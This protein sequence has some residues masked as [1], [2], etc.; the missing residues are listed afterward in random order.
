MTEKEIDKL[1]E[2][3]RKRVHKHI[4]E[5]VEAYMYVLQYREKMRLMK[6]LISTYRN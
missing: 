4:N 5:Q 3:A 1:F 2:E 6:N